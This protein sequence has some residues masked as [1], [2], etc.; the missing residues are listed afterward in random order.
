MSSG[1]RAY[2]NV[3]YNSVAPNFSDFSD[4]DY[5]H[6]IN[7]GAGSGEAHQSLSTGGDPFVDIENLD[8]RLKTSIPNG[9][10]FSAPYNK[11]MYG[12]TRGSDGIWEKGSSEFLENLLISAPANPSVK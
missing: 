4:H 8:F 2:N 3:W 7:S 11:D 12:S 9:L 5:N 6:F 10:S 1:N